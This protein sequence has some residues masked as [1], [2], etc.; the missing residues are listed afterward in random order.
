MKV[1]ISTS[2]MKNAKKNALRCRAEFRS[3]SLSTFRHFITSCKRNGRWIATWNQF[4]P[5]PKNFEF[6]IRS[7]SKG[8]ERFVRIQEIGNVH[9]QTS[10][11]TVQS[12]ERREI[13]PSYWNIQSITRTIER[14]LVWISNAQAVLYQRLVPISGCTSRRRNEEYRYLVWNLHGKK[15]VSIS[16]N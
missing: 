15:G 3:L 12:S 5:A 16:F 6:D 11:H 13:F 1:S 4:L 9:K 14:Y 2:G 7:M 10:N 8:F